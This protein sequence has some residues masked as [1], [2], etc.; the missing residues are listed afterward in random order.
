MSEPALS[1][2]DRVWAATQTFLAMQ[3]AVLALIIDAGE[4]E[5][6]RIAREKFHDQGFTTEH[7]RSMFMQ[8]R[9]RVA[10]ARM[11][12]EEQASMA[13]D[14]EARRKAIVG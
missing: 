12:A 6:F 8:M 3:P 5:F 13:A 10:K 9:H 4:D 7:L 2:T 14:T 1:M 11:E